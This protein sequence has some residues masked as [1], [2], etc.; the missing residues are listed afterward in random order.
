MDVYNGHAI[1]V[2]PLVNTSFNRSKSNLKALEAGA[3]GL[4]FVGSK[5]HPYENSLDDGVVLLADGKPQWRT[6][7]KRLVEDETY[8]R[9]ILPAKLRIE[10]EYL[11]RRT[12]PGDMRI[13]AQTAS[14]LFTKPPRHGANRGSQCQS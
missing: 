10:L 4:A 8:R 6:I 7:L 5:V 13:L 3:K 2:A 14:A 1:S 11:S 12:L 9:E